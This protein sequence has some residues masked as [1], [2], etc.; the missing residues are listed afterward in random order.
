VNYNSKM[1][2]QISR[3]VTGIEELLRALCSI[4]DRNQRLNIAISDLEVTK[5]TCIDH[6]ELRHSLDPFKFRLD[7]MIVKALDGVQYNDFGLTLTSDQS[8]KINSLCILIF[9][10][11]ENLNA[12][13]LSEKGKFDK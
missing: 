4:H 12:I 8:D 2:D 11:V 9:K 7:Q 6:I 5:K 1:V 3:I 10:E 13:T